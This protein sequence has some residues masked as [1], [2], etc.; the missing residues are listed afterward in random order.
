MWLPIIKPKAVMFYVPSHHRRELWPAIDRAFLEPHQYEYAD[1]VK[2]IGP[3][4]HE[5]EDSAFFKTIIDK[6]EA[7]IWRTAYM[8]AM[9]WIAKDSIYIHF[10]ATMQTEGRPQDVPARD[11]M[12]DIIIVREMSQFTGHMDPSDDGKEPKY[13]LDEF[14]PNLYTDDARWAR[15][16]VHPG[17]RVMRDNIAP[18]FIGAYRGWDKEQIDAWRKANL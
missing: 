10:P 8:D 15:D 6:R 9:S 16:M 17:P 1:Y 7:D 11:N 12:N 18:L 5:N 2:S 3:W 4:S 14:S 13:T